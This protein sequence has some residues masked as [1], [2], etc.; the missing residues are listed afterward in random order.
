MHLLVKRNKETFFRTIL[1]SLLQSKKCCWNVSCKKT[2]STVKVHS[3]IQTQG[4]KKGT[5]GK[6]IK[7]KEGKFKH[8]IKTWKLGKGGGQRKIYPVFGEVYQN[9]Q[10]I[11]NQVRRNIKKKKKASHHCFKCETEPQNKCT[12]LWFGNKKQKEN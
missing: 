3:F 9:L 4:R 11:C 2:I 6:K 10:R 8:R 12:K 7:N 5:E 1:M